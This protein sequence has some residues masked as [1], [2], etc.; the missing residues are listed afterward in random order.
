MPA[1]EAH[2]YSMRVLALW[3]LQRHGRRR[4]QRLHGR[5]LLPMSVT[6]SAAADAIPCVNFRGAKRLRMEWDVLLLAISDSCFH[7]TMVESGRAGEE[8]KVLLTEEKG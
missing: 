7:S 8:K 6:V 4:R 1:S 3:N 5:P 2:P